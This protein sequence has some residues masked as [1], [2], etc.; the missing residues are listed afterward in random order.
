MPLFFFL[1]G[2]LMYKPGR[3]RAGAE[4]L[5]FLKGKATVQLVPTL[6]FTAAL[7]LVFR[8]SFTALW[9]DKA[10]DG[11]WFTV[12]LFYFFVIYALG[13]RLLGRRLHGR[14]K[15]LAGTVVAALVYAFSKFSLSSACPWSGSF[16]SG[17]VGYANFQFFIFFFFGAVIRSRFEAFQQWLDGKWAA[18]AVVAG[19]VVLQLVLH[20][21][22]SRS[23][24]VS[25]LS[26][27]AYSLVKSFSGFFGITLILACFR[28]YRDFFET[29]R[30]GTGLQSIGSRTL[31][32]YLIHYFLL[33]NS[34]MGYFGELFSRYHSPV[35]EL[36]VVTA[37]SL[38]IVA[39]CLLIS[40]ILRC[41]DVLAKLLF[42][43]V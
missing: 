36:L 13:D 33:R 40:R 41:S 5:R 8:R 37:L 34:D 18:L 38:C 6:I 43:K 35:A 12:T 11:Y 24:M 39:L 30:I 19:F 29:T 9:L 16:L 32:I 25:T 15:L 2:F 10:K 23:W 26:Y 17:F 31:D 7:C 1:S 28:K 3:F 4:V 22:Q 42:G 27:P 21:P 20:L 14:W